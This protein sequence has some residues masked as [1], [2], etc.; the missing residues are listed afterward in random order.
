MDFVANT[1]LC[2]VS[3]CFSILRKSGMIIS[4]CSRIR[5]C[6]FIGGIAISAFLPSDVPSRGIFTPYEIILT[7]AKNV[8]DI[9]NICIYLAEILP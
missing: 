8:G 9:I 6:S 3:L 1:L 4:N 5:N 2:K 7:Y